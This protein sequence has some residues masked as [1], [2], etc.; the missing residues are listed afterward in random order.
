MPEF[1][2]EILYF[3]RNA[4]IYFLYIKF[5]NIYFEST[6]AFFDIYKIQTNPCYGLI[7]VPTINSYVE[8]LTL[9][10]MV[11]EDEAFGR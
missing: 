3:I 8:N 11:F 10:D 9:N 2:S 5:L 4:S 7:C 6:A 1:F